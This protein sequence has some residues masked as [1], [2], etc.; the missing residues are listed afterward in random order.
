MR[1][2]IVNP[3]FFVYGGA[4]L[5]IVELCRHLA[6]QNIEHALLTTAIIPEVAQA[7]PKTRIILS[8]CG[9]NNLKIYFHLWRAVRRHAAEYDLINVH[10]FPAEFSAFLRRQP[11]VWMCNEPELYLRK[12]NTKT[13]R[14]KMLGAPVFLFERWIVRN[15]IN[16]TIVSDSFNARR[17]KSLYGIE[18]NVIHYGIDYEFFS[19]PD[20]S[21]VNR[22]KT[23]WGKRFVMLHVG[24]MTPLK[25]QLRSLQVLCE[26][27]QRIPDCLLVLAGCWENAY[28]SLLDRFIAE[29]Q[30]AENVLFTGHID[31]QSLKNYYHSCNVLLHPVSSQGGWLA[32]FEALCAGLPIVVAP[33]MTASDLITREHLGIV[34]GNYAEVV[35]NIYEQPSSYQAMARHGKQWVRENLSWNKFCLGMLD[36]FNA[37]LAGENRSCSR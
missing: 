3:R 1:V 22:L 25:N 14:G 34:T 13:R 8:P 28:K 11:V 21:C 9:W 35:R 31:R 24:I 33:E 36:V 23:Q 18:P 4:E 29:N 19:V 12:I 30:L 27:K 10:N 32:P 37:A 7:L 16:K 26:V 6:R 17:F 20:E 2:L 15:F 5:L